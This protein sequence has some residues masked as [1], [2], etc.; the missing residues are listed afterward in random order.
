MVICSH[1]AHILPPAMLDVNLAKHF[2]LAIPDNFKSMDHI[3]M[4]AIGV[5]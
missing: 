4:T 1:L 3:Y 5:L 2:R